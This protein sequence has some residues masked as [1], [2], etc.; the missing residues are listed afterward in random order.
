LLLLRKDG[1]L[2]PLL[3]KMRAR[4]V[5]GRREGVKLG[6]MKKILELFIMVQSKTN[7]PFVTF[8]ANETFYFV[9]KDHCHNKALLA[10][11]TPQKFDSA[12]KNL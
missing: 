10:R 3:K 7:R 2:K 4:S 8:K 1:H 12:L 5:L 11:L 6:K 9:D